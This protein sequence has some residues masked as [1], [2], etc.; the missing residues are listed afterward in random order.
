MSPRNFARAYAANRVAAAS[1][2]QRRTS[3]ECSVWLLCFKS[4]EHHAGFK[5]NVR[6][7][8]SFQPNFA[9]KSNTIFYREQYCI[10]A[11]SAD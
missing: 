3:P 2:S 7:L 6:R 9:K 8:C 1:T 4:A 11:K 5:L 10:A